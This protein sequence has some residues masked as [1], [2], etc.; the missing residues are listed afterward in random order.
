[1]V[2]R[3]ALGGA[4][5]G[6]AGEV[7][8]CLQA[9]LLAERGAERTHLVE[10]ERARRHRRRDAA[11]HEEQIGARPRELVERREHQPPGVA[12]A[13]EGGGELDRRTQQRELLAA[14]RGDD[15][16]LRRQRGEAARRVGEEGAR[17]AGVDERAAQRAQRRV[18]R[19]RVGVAERAADHRRDRIRR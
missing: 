3:A 5:R 7:D 2:R 15:E 12:L 16:A 4:P 9:G 14:R 8:A 10:A 6:A 1:M 13:P 18:H 17:L 19:R 11:R